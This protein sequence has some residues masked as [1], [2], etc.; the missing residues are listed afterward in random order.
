MIADLYSWVV[1]QLHTNQFFGAAAFASLTAAVFAALKG[2]PSL[3]YDKLLLLITYKVTIYQTD[4]IHEHITSWVADNYSHKA[5]NVE[6]STEH[7]Y[8]GEQLTNSKSKH[9]KVIKEI[10]ISDFFYLRVHRRLIKIS[11]MREKLEHA[12]DLRSVYL[13]NY[14]IVGVFAGSAIRRLVTEINQKYGT[15]KH[16][17][18]FYSSKSTYFE[19][20]QDIKGKPL[21]QVVI[22][23]DLKTELLSDICTWIDSKDEYARRGITHKRGH[24]YYGPPGTGKTT[25]VRAIALEYGMNIYNVN[26]NS[27]DSDDAMLYMLA[28]VEPHSIIL[29]EDIDA[30][31]Q[32]R[33]CIMKNAKISFSGLLNVLDGA[34]GLNDVF[35]IM[36]TNHI[37]DIDPALLRPGRIDVVKELGFANS[38]EIN[39]YLSMFYNKRLSIDFSACI[40]MCNIQNV[41]LMYPNESEHAID[42]IR[43]LNC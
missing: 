34:I 36:T 19:Y 32:K 27:I 17:P 10:P 15:K 9:A 2:V 40:P 21:S 12:N 5:K 16:E 26:L 4:E 41:C 33:S 35:I 22:Q 20:I 37:E 23:N 6:Y 11:F 28:S 39:E 8:N 43:A 42:A 24:C 3:L 30:Y 14:V 25:L 29:F 13:K 38:V 1:V 31:F 7:S 18:R